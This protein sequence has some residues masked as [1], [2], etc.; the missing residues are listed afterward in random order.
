MSFFEQTQTDDAPET[1][2]EQA[3]RAYYRHEFE[4]FGDAPA[5]D[6]QMARLAP[7]IEA[8]GPSTVNP[9]VALTSGRRWTGG[10]RGWRRG[11]RRGGLLPALVAAA[12]V[13]GAAAFVAA[14]LVVHIIGDRLSRRWP[15]QPPLL[16]GD[17]RAHAAHDQHLGR[18]VH[19]A[20]TFAGQTMTVDWIYADANRIVVDYTVQASSGQALGCSPLSL[21]D[22]YLTDDAGRQYPMNPNDPYVPLSLHQQ[23]FLGRGPSVACEVVF[24]AV[25]LAGSPPTTLHMHL[26]LWPYCAGEPVFP[27][28]PDPRAQAALAAQCPTPTS[29][30]KSLAETLAQAHAGPPAFAFDLAIPFYG[31]IPVTLG[32]TLTADGKTV[33]LERVVVAPSETRLFVHVIDPQIGLAPSSPPLV[34]SVTVDGKTAYP[35]IADRADSGFE[36]VGCAQAT[37]QED[38]FDCPPDPNPSLDRTS[39]YVVYHL[40]IPVVAVQGQWVVTFRSD[41]PQMPGDKNPPPTWTFRFQI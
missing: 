2:V 14:P 4:R 5:T 23:V 20:E 18:D 39:E 35:P 40:G 31:G 25:A 26:A 28:S 30:P 22:E 29:W 1:N 16:N 17:P 7:E 13:M 38:G 24:D 12:L 34:T 6:A 3:L 32:Q 15:D 41:E 33:T 21:L 9:T 10:R 19:L 37:N 36:V 11:A 27:G 8:D